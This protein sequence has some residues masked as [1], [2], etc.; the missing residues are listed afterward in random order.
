MHKRLEPKLFTILREGY[1][2]ELFLA[3]LTAGVI[4]GIVAL[5]L[6]IAF[7]IASGVKPE[8]GLITAII[9]GFIV[10]AFGG[11]RVQIAGPTGAFIV[12]VY[13]ILEQYGFQG[14]VIATIMA[15]FLLIIMGFARLGTLLKFIPYPLT[16][17][18]TSGIALIIFS[19]QIKDLF[20]LRIQNLPADFIEKWI[21]YFEKMSTINLD[22]LLV[23]VGSLVV[24]LLWSRITHRVPGPLVAI[25]LATAV[26][27]LFHIPVETI[28]S[29]FGE[30]PSNLP[31][32]HSPH[33]TWK[34]ITNLVSPAI[35]IALLGSIESLLSA[36]VADGMTRT[37]HRSNMELIAQG[38]A[39]IASPL[40]GGLPAT[41]AIARTATN[42]K[43]GGRTPIA[44]IIHSI[45]LF[46]IMIFFGKW[47]ALIP[48]PALAAILIVVAYNMSEWHSFVKVL[49]SPK[50]D[51][52]V[53]LITFGLTVLIDLTVAIEVGIVLAAL[54]FMRRMSEV[55]HVN[56][57]TRDLQEERDEED[58]GMSRRI[59]PQGV[60]VFE[61]YGTLFF[62]AVDQFTES[63]RFLVKKPRV[64]IL[65]TRNLLAIDATGIHA[66]E[67]L[68][69]E[70]SQ[71]KIHLI[72]SGIHKQPLFAMQ[73]AGIF[74]QIG[75]DNVCGNLDEALERA[76]VLLT[77]ST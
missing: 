57:I 26:V 12:I 35:T 33:I 43:N 14:L 19:S 16:I 2:K 32:P 48:L 28:G 74:D 15:G 63:M 23:G 31:A 38:I 1:T 17:G 5:P 10:S 6:S 73:Q 18:F 34:T 22:A 36:V 47:A 37:R 56:A 11:S 20:G 41:G 68:I 7:A 53:M 55:S 3:D 66:V 21:L 59:I 30:V 45:T 46:L 44:G 50:S 52:A 58:T 67:N 51:V 27:H 69:P 49:R 71:Q 60:E 8:Q 4:V 61:V 40:F 70:L 72:I 65:E 75:E 13:G 54:L 29:R 64:L 62:G 76:H 42:V 24:I 77:I 39:N 9:A 25:L